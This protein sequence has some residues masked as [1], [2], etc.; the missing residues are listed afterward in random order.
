MRQKRTTGYE[1]RI[2]RALEQG[3]KPM[4]VRQLAKEL[5]EAYP[6]V[7]GATY[8]GVRHYMTGTV[9][10][11]SPELLRAIADVLG[12]RFE[13]LA[14]GEGA[15]TAEAEQVRS[16]A[17]TPEEDEDWR[18]QPEVAA[19][20]EEWPAL[21]DEAPD[22]ANA[23]TILIQLFNAYRVFDPKLPWSNEEDV[24]DLARRLTRAMRAPLDAL[25]IQREQLWMTEE[26]PYLL[27]MSAALLGPL[28]GAAVKAHQNRIFTQ[29]RGLD[30]EA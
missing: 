10:N 3:P 1:R 19:M 23:L 11:P 12:V 27:N 16:T 15:M 14:Y 26:L 6:D 24:V 4:S 5:A 28:H 20:I 30:G 7:R 13:F 21:A 8:G 25:G 17:A 9:A 22:G 29:Q 2:A 18:S